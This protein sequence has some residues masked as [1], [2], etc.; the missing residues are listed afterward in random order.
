MLSI[1]S[2]L[3]YREYLNAMFEGKKQESLW[4][5]FKLMGDGVGLDQ[6]QVYRILQKQLPF[7]NQLCL[8]FNNI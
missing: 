5:S 1:Y 7:L 3:D 6:S 8:G 4:Y 2:F